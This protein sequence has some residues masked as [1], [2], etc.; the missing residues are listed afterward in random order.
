MQLSI[1]SYLDF[2]NK[3]VISC[4]IYVTYKFFRIEPEF[5]F[6]LLRHKRLPKEVI[7]TFL[8]K[9]LQQANTA[10]CNNGGKEYILILKMSC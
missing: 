2:R 1:F 10:R 3:I 6:Y 5:Y 9:L 7:I 4:N 8:S